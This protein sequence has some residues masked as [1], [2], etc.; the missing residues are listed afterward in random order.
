MKNIIFLSLLDSVPDPDPNPYVFGSRS[1]SIIIVY[2]YK[3]FHQQAK[4]F[5]KKS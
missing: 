3:S 5:T 1:R 2:E 4:K